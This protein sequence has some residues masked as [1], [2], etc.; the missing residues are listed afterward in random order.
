MNYMIYA[1]YKDD[2]RFGPVDL[3]SGSVGVGLVFATLITDIERA[4][5]YAAKLKEK[6]PDFAFQVREA[7]KSK[8][9]FT[10]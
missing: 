7:G 6:S 3:H 4:K 9:V 10:A 1:K 5:E 2:K 8:V